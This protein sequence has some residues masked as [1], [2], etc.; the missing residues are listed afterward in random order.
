MKYPHKNVNACATFRKYTMHSVTGSQRSMVYFIQNYVFIYTFL[1][2]QFIYICQNKLTNFQLQFN[3]MRKI[4]CWTV[5]F[6]VILSICLNFLSISRSFARI[7]S[8]IH[9][10]NESVFIA[11]GDFPFVIIYNLHIFSWLMHIYTVS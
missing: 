5:F 6:P 7:H 1:K 11:F 4:N 9:S 2:T 10:I 3:W 8:I